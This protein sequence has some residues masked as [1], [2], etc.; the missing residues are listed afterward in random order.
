M[1]DRSDPDAN[2]AL[3]RRRARRRFVARVDF[4]DDDPRTINGKNEHHDVVD[5]KTGRVAW[6][7]R[8]GDVD[9]SQARRIADLLNRGR[10]PPKQCPHCG[11]FL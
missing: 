7:D 3:R 5:T 1:T 9:G 8:N 4:D 11:G 2:D 6:K 10:R